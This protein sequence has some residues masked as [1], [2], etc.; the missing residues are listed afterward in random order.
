MSRYTGPKLR[1]MRR[2]GT[3]IG[4]KSR[5]KLSVTKRLAVSPGVHGHKNV[6][7]KTSAYGL[8][9]REKQ[10]VRRM[11]GMV[12]RQFR[13]FFD[14]ALRKKG[15]TGENFLQL[16]ESRLDNVVYRAGFALTRAAARQLVSH[17]HVYVNEKRVNIPSYLVNINDKIEIKE[18]IYEAAPV[19][20]S[21]ETIKENE[22]P[23][24]IERKGRVAKYMS[25]PRREQIASG[26]NEASIIEFYS[27]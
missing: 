4:L 22:L 5:Q 1:I 18:K 16:L 13:R 6:R 2:E 15:N 23:A 20:N 7:K 9:L 17:G 24:W 19:Q 27:R 11:Y 10:K 14:L 21:I 8:Q 26:I 12:E 3:D 25:L